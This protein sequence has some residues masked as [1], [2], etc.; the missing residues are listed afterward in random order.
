MAKE[1]QI[2]QITNFY[3]NRNHYYIECG[4]NAANAKKKQGAVFQKKI[5]QVSEKSPLRKKM[6]E[7]RG[8]V[9][10]MLISDHT[11]NLKKMGSL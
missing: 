2:V 11:L 4:R 8:K 7:I 10:H 6:S 9:E 1:Y 5:L 3:Y